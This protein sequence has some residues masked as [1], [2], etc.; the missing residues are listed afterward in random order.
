M[1]KVID[2]IDLNG[3]KATNAATPTLPTDLSTKGYTDQQ[4]QA[5]QTTATGVAAAM[6]LV[7]GS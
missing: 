1:A 4:V 2:G 6:A 5:T 3:Q 7:F